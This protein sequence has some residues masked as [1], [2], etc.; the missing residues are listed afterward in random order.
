MD[1][2]QLICVPLGMSNLTLVM[3]L[4]M[5]FR[6]IAIVPLIIVMPRNFTLREWV[7]LLFSEFTFSFSLFSINLLMCC[8]TLC[9]DRLVLTK[10]LQSSAKRQN[11][12]PRFSSS[13]SSSSRTR[14]LSRGLRGLPWTEPSLVGDTKPS[15]ITPLLRML[16]IKR[17]MRLSLINIPRRVMSLSWF[18]LSKKFGQVDVDRVDL[19]SFNNLLCCFDRLPLISLGSKA[20][21]VVWKDLF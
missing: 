13:L 20:K 12:R 8:M 18:I 10:I 15:I 2:S 19:A 16:P 7:A 14:L 3:A 5:D 21:A 4:F 9:A 17:R 1:S 6:E 11:S